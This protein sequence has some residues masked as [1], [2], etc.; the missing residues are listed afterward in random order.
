MILIIMLMIKQVSG[1][2]NQEAIA[3]VIKKSNVPKHQ[4]RDNNHKIKRVNYSLRN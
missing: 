4:F 3:L 2:I 1:R